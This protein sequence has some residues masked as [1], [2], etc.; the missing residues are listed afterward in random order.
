MSLLL[1]DD[2]AKTAIPTGKP[3]TRYY[4]RVFQALFNHLLTDAFKDIL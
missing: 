2:E 1:V 3:F 4:V